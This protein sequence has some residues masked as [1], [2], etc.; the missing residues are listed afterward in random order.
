[1]DTLKINSLTENRCGGRKSLCN[2][3]KMEVLHKDTHDFIPTEIVV[4][5]FF[6]SIPKKISDKISGTVLTYVV[7]K[8]KNSKH[9]AGTSLISL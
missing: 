6:C 9:P 8:I 2:G 3:S 7:L 5:H 1:M 4:D